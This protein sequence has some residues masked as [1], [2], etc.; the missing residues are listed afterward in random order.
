MTGA[1]GSSGPD[2]SLPLQVRGG[3]GCRWRSERRSVRAGRPARSHGAP[4]RPTAQPKCGSGIVGLDRPAVC[5][6]QCRPELTGQALLAW[7]V[8][9][10][11]DMDGP[12]GCNG[13]PRKCQ[14]LSTYQHM[15]ANK[16]LGLRTVQFR[17]TVKD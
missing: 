5:A 13:A 11:Q 12:E 10:S 8:G 14:S 17:D 6:S 16:T 1:S 15:Y 9:H 7:L 2:Y 4:N 3:G